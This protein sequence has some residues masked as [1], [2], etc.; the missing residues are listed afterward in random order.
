MKFCDKLITLRAKAGLSQEGLANRLG[1][2]RQAVSKWEAGAT[3]PELA[4]IIAIADLFDTTT[5]Y[6]LR[7]EITEEATIAGKDYAAVATHLAD[8]SGYVKRQQP[9]EYK[10]E[11]TAFGL[12][13]VHVHLSRGRGKPAVAKGIIAIGDVAMGVLSV[14][15]IALGLAAFGGVSLGLLLAIGGM[16]A[17]TLVFGGFGI[18]VFVMGGLAIGVYSF[19]G[20]AVAMRLAVGG[21]A[22]SNHAAIGG[23]AQA[24]HALLAEEA[25]KA[26]II[27]FISAHC[28]EAG[29]WLMRILTAS[30][31]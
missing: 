15:G 17:G 20:C 14:G 10:S 2:S 4:K 22:I 6:L 9:Y 13:L 18:G 26:D 21:A 16:A 5:D 30:A 27:R 24:P 11:A 28:P 7:D 25:A 12:P 31:K 8:I 3:M 1:V 29:E 23:A 19:G